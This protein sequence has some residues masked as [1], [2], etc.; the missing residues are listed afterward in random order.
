MDMRITILMEAE[1][2]K[3]AT[4]DKIIEQLAQVANLTYVNTEQL[5]EDGVNGDVFYNAHGECYPMAIEDT[6]YSF[7][8][9]GGGF[10]HIGGMPFEKAMVYENKSWRPFV[11]TLGDIR[12]NEGSGAL[13]M[14]I[15]VFRARL[16]FTVYSPP[17]KNDALD[18]KQ[19]FD[20]KLVGVDDFYE[21]LPESGLN[22]TTTVPL[23]LTSPELEFLDSRAYHA[24]PICRDTIFAGWVIAPDGQKVMP[25]LL[26]TKFWG[27]PY[28][29]N[30]S[31]VP[32]PWAIFTGV[33]DEDLPQAVFDAMIRWMKVP[34]VLKPIDLPYAT[35]HE[36]ESIL[37]EP[38]LFGSLPDDY[39]L[40]SYQSKSNKEDIKLQKTPSWVLN[41]SETIQLNYDKYALLQPVRFELVDSSDTVL[42]YVESA[43]A[44]WDPEPLKTTRSIKSNG[45]YLDDIEQGEVKTRSTWLSGTNW[46]DRYQYALSWHN[47]NPLRIAQDAVDLHTC[48][49]AIIRTHYFMPG[50]IR[51][52]LGEIFAETHGDFYSSFEEGPL[53]SERHIRAIE[54]YVAILSHMDLVFMPTLYTM[55][56]PEMGNPGHWAFSSRLVLVQAYREAQKA[57]AKQIMDRFGECASISWDICNE[58]NTEMYRV[59]EWLTDMRQIW[60]R[61]GQS[62]G[63]GTYRLNDNVALGESADWHSIHT[64]CCKTPDTFRTGKPCM[65]QE[66]WVPTPSTP[67]GELDLEHHLN[68]GF[69][70]TLK[71]GG[72]SLMPWNYNMSMINW[73]YKVGFTDYWDL[74]LGCCVHPDATF[75]SGYRVMK[76]WAT[77]LHGI[78]FDQT[79]N[80]QVVF[81]YPKTCLQGG[82]PE[83]IEYLNERKIPFTGVND[84]A[85]HNFDLNHTKVIFAPY[86]GLG[87]SDS[88]WKRLLEFAESGGLVFAHNDNMQLNENGEFARDRSIPK[89]STILRVGDG[90]IRWNMGFNQSTPLSIC[91]PNLLAEKKLVKR[92][93]N[94]IPIQDGRIVFT[95]RLS[96]DETTMPTDWI[97]NDPLP[98]R[99]IPIK[100]EF[101]TEDGEVKRAW[102]KENIP[103]PMCSVHVTGQRPVF[104]IRISNKEFVVAGSDVKIYT[105]Q[106]HSLKLKLVD[107]TVVGKTQEL[108]C[109]YQLKHTITEDALQIHCQNWQAMHWIHV[110]VQSQH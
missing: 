71:F 12:N 68:K 57:F 99:M 28:N 91:D 48:G 77:L 10:L 97:P 109:V 72:C 90:I 75:R 7:F 41:D 37:I 63:I 17:Y 65:L 104:A 67:E 78:S 110:T 20:E 36:G 33:L 102:T 53:I 13:D 52:M 39:R 66:A 42:D 35:L 50:W 3:H 16:G 18:W 6:L 47:P 24:R 92:K 64:P 93:E 4:S 22:L 98:S 45:S 83:Y 8:S 105:K 84:S 29:K 38:S 19:V 88:T 70:W 15:D 23:E 108:D 1:M 27:N 85:F 82:G 34:A 79:L 21:C 96:T 40:V 55:T 87:Y 107:Y 11:R 43:V 69:A 5:L 49:M 9:E 61:T 76:N 46:Q 51:V 73:R 95:D 54:A 89:M 56:G 2:P 80:R 44:T 30:Q 86:Y 81:I 103:I 94:T 14:P 25:S 32:R 60:G 59:S 26:L 101:Q 58:L 74:E 31:I 62:L 100:I 106:P